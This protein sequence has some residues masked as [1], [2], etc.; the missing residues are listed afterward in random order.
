MKKTLRL[1]S[2]NGIEQYGSAEIAVGTARVHLNR[3]GPLCT[4]TVT[5]E[6]EPA[7]VVHAWP[8]VTPETIRAALQLADSIDHT[9]EKQ[10]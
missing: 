8:E 5:R 2:R 9:K 10:T 4:V 1:L 7:K 6:A 3:A